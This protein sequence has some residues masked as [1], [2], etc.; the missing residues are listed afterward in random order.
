[1]RSLEDSHHGTRG[2]RQAQARRVG[3]YLTAVAI[4]A[5]YDVRRRQ[6]GRAQLAA[7]TGLSLA[8][9]CRT[10]DGKTLPLPSQLTKWAAG[11]NLDHR[12]ML[13]ES[14]FIPEQ[15]QLHLAGREVAA[16]AL[17]PDEAMN[18]WGITDPI[19]RRTLN[20]TIVHAIRL[21]EELD[22]DGGREA[23]LRG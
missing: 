12:V 14:G 19:I 8:T 4:A 7:V 10:L 2:S 6:G 18:A 5:G 9:V 16:A 21:Q 23:A 15:Q 1:M 3:A 17:S 20:G 11:L 22:A 13:L